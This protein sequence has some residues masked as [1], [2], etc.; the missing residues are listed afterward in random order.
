VQDIVL[1]GL[2]TQTY[3]LVRRFDTLPL[4]VLEVSP[5]AL[6]RLQASAEI[7]ALEEDSLSGPHSIAP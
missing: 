1:Q 4:L 6:A 7:I 3:R 2:D 5:A